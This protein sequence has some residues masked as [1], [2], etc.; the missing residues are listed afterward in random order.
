MNDKKKTK[1]PEVK[2][3][4]V[5][6]PKGFSLLGEI[7]VTSSQATITNVHFYKNTP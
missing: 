3:P 4:E 6:L 2:N 7:E 1:N 5:A